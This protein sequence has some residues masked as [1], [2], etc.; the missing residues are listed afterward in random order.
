MSQAIARYKYVSR[1]HF[2]Y[3]STNIYYSSWNGTLEEHPLPLYMRLQ[4]R[5]FL[6][7]TLLFPN[8]NLA[9]TAPANLANIGIH[10]PRL[11]FRIFVE[12]KDLT[13]RSQPLLFV[14]LQKLERYHKKLRHTV[15]T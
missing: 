14:Y 11:A 10:I 3:S 4:V 15:A 1:C 7:F 13:G 5:L 9:R 12:T 6:P 2:A 8:R